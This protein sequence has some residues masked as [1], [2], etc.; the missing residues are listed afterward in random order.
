MLFQTWFSLFTGWGCYF[1]FGGVANP[2]GRVGF[3]DWILGRQDVPGWDWSRRAILNWAGLGW[4]GL[5]WTGPTGLLLWQRGFGSL[6]LL[7]LYFLQLVW[8]IDA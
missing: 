8:S 5:Q 4:R 1:G 6:F 2:C 3:A 7:G